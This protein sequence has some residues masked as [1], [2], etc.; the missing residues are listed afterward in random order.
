[1]ATV[2]GSY[3][4]RTVSGSTRKWRAQMT[5]TTSYTDTTYSVVCTAC[6]M[7][8]SGGSGTTIKCTKH[9]T[10]YTLAATGQTSVAKTSNFPTSDKNVNGSDDWTMVSSH[11]FTWNRTHDA[12]SVRISWQ[13]KQLS[14]SSWHGTSTAYAPSS[15]TYITIPAKPS[16]TISYNANGGSW[17]I[18]VPSATKWYGE[19]LTTDNGGGLIRKGYDFAGWKWNNAGSIVAGNTAWNGANATGTFYAQWTVRTTPLYI[20][21]AGAWRKIIL[22]MKINGGWIAPFDGYIKVNGTWKKLK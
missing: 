1:M 10:N 2:S 3:V 19:A 5:Y 14:D 4:E 15:S 8:L 16:Y 9:N 18:P 20:K 17:I 11:T 12:Q 22:R 7:D 21:V 13:V 6:K